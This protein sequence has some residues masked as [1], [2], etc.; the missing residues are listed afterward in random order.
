MTTLR[1]APYTLPAAELGP[2]NPLPM[3]RGEEDDVAVELDA[4]VP[5]EDRWYMGWRIAHRV[6]PHRM[7]DCYTRRKRVRDLDSV[8]LENDRLKAT[9]LTQYG[10]RLVSLVHKG[11]G[12]E[13]LAR[14]PVFQPAN[15]ALRN[16][17]FSGGIEWNSGQ[18]GHHYLTCSPLFVAEVEGIDG[19]PALRLYEWDRV[20]G[21]TWQIDFVLPDGSDV[22]L[23]HTRIV[24][25]HDEPIAMYWWTNIAVDEREDVRVLIPA[26]TALCNP[27]WQAMSVVDLPVVA[28]HDVTYSTRTPHAFDFFSRI[29]EERRRWVAALDVRGTGFFEVSTGRLR[30]RKLFCWGN[31]PGGRRWQEFLA[32]P[33]HAYIE[34]QSGLARTQMESVPMP[35]QAEWAWT[36]AFGYLEADPDRVHGEDWKAAWEAAG[37]QIERHVPSALLDNLDARLAAV[38]DRA[39]RHVLR[40]GSGWGALELAR[41]QAQGAARRL[42]ISL[43]FGE[44]SMGPDQAPWL[45][46]LRQ[47]A[48]PELDP[49]EEPG[50]LMVQA[51]WQELLEQSVRT[52]AGDH[53]L[54]WWHLGNARLEA[55]DTAGACEAWERSVERTPNGWSLRNLAVAARRRGEPEKSRALMLQAW[56]QGPPIAPLAVEYARD[57]VADGLFEEALAFVSSLPESVRSQERVLLLR[58]RAAL[59]TGVLDGVE[60]VFDHDFATIREGEVTLSDLWFALHERRI[61]QADGV[62]IDE[63]LRARVRKEYPPP[64]HIDFRM[65][66][67]A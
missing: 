67:E 51:E 24:N 37:E 16:A 36:E 19:E 40:Q 21:Y 66:G 32:E 3:F 17:W 26:E 50:A 20:K 29:P 39:P 10:G 22:L 33:G 34:I 52:P 59:E 61:A 44:A 56:L 11:E 1:I 8:V 53:W 18:C 6:L 49:A 28:G 4:S 25:P 45:A 7:Q 41:I 23:A 43:A 57:L 2:E 65:A 27:Y 15:L 30:G 38:S 31:G 9:F 42:P 35:A 58:A 13:L 46:L 62:P 5:A 60:G 47:G 55:R 54:S 14:N 64:R 12:R 48:L 63:D